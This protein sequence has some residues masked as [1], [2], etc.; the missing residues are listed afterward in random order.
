VHANV[1]RK[2]FKPF[3][4]L[5]QIAHFLL[6]LRT[7]VQLRFLLACL[8]QRHPQFERHQLRQLIHEIIRQIQHASDVAHH[9]LCSHGSESGNL[10]NTLRAILLL[11]VFDHVFAPVLAEIYIEVRHGYAFGIEKP[12][13]E[14]IVA[15]RVKVGN[16]Q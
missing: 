13:E 7:L 9:R 16:P 15:K 12:L 4:Q 3:R 2:S 10:G 6:R 5:Q 11:H 1:A 8:F 14:Q